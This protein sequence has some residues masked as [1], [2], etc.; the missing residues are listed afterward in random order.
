[1]HASF[2]VAVA[3]SGA[4]RGHFCERLMCENAA[5]GQCRHVAQGLL[6]QRGMR[7]TGGCDLY[8]V[9]TLENRLHRSRIY[10]ISGIIH[11]PKKFFAA[12]RH[13][14]ISREICL[15]DPHSVRAGVFR[16]GLLHDVNCSQCD[17]QPQA[18]KPA[19][20]RCLQTGRY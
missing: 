19:T 8:G 14:H 15:P 6:S 4:N 12:T 5:A 9:N 1:M 20:A 13:W 16:G 18:V 3:G 10:S 2:S 7:T 11:R 17:C